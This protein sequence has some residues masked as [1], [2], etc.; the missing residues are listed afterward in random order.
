MTV[1]QN[2]SLIDT[3][4]VEM[5]NRYN[6]MGTSNAKYHF[7]SAFSVP[8]HRFSTLINVSRGSS[9]LATIFIRFFPSACRFKSFIRRV[10]SPPYFAINRNPKENIFENVKRDS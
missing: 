3:C 9:M 2:P 6:T 4:E 7:D 5:L 10:M 8:L 1:S